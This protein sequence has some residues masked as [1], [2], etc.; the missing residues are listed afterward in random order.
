MGFQNT[1]EGITPQGGAGGAATP[2]QLQPGQP[3]PGFDPTGGTPTTVGAQGTQTFAN[4]PQLTTPSAQL[5][6]RWGPTAQAQFLGFERART[7]A[8]PQ[9]TQFRLG[10]GRAPTGRFGGFSGFSRT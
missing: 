7:G 4:L 5:Q 10:S 8:A 2:G 1:G 3:I 9:E 6:A